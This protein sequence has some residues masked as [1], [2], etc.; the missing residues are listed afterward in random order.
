[1]CETCWNDEERKEGAIKDR[2]F[3]M[4]GETSRTG[5]VRC[6]EHGAALERKNNSNLWDQCML[7]HGGEQAEF[8]YKVERKF[9][10]DSLLRQIEEA[11]RLESEQGTILNDKMEFVQPFGV[12]LKATRMGI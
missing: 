8:K 12:Q 2:R 3:V 6:S 10:K 9:N 4:H 11:W 7:E 1:M 5:R